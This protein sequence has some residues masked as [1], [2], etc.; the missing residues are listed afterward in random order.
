[1]T[2]AHTLERM[3]D[4]ARTIQGVW[5]NDLQAGDW[6]IV[7]TKNS[8]YTLASL[9]DGRFQVSGGWFAT[10]GG[11]S[12]LIRVLGCTWGGRAILTDMI[13]AP[14]MFIEFDNGVQTTRVQHVRVMRSSDT[15]H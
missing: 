8:T 13:A 9:G 14:G 10:H 4:N 15:T 6:V 3:A 2:G 1:M 12:R 5:A 7:R 11:Y